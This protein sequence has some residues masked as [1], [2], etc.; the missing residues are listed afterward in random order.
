MANLTT[1]AVIAFK[2]MFAL[3]GL[4][5]PWFMYFFVVVL[6]NRHKIYFVKRTVSPI[7]LEIGIVGILTAVVVPLTVLHQY[8]GYF[9]SLTAK[10][11]EILLQSLFFGFC[12]MFGLA[13]GGHF[14]R[15]SQT[16]LA[17]ENINICNHNQAANTSNSNTI[18]ITTE[19][20]SA[21][22]THTTGSVNE[23]NPYPNWIKYFINRYGIKLTFVLATLIALIL[24]LIESIC[25]A[26][27]ILGDYDHVEKSIV[28]GM[29]SLVLF[30]CTIIVVVFKKYKI[31]EFNDFWFITQELKIYIRAFI[32]TA[33]IMAIVGST[34]LAAKNLH[35]YQPGTDWDVVHAMSCMYVVLLGLYLSYVASIWIIMKNKRRL[36]KI[37]VNYAS[38]NNNSGMKKKQTKHKITKFRQFFD[39]NFDIENEYLHIIAEFG[40]FV[41][42]CISECAVEHLLFWINCVQLS[43]YINENLLTDKG[44]QIIMGQL[45]KD[46]KCD[47][48]IENTMLIKK[49]KNDCTIDQKL[50]DTIVPYTMFYQSLFEQFI[51]RNRA[52]FEINISH[53]LRETLTKDYQIIVQCNIDGNNINNS[54][55][56]DVFIHQIWKDIQETAI[57]VRILIEGSFRRFTTTPN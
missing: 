50:R 26:V 36:E 28:T 20:V 49:L 8:F 24:W 7:L 11:T 13:Y 23:E 53:E 6:R 10:F 51:E 39:A 32:V 46:Y 57:Q 4:L 19:T 47:H 52:P 40:L 12:N 48:F 14:I 33:I 21:N 1:A 15:M 22:T 27:I 2:I 9:D 29:D 35:K 38:N 3:D 42:H 17:R 31:F 41:N 44:E 54:N 5:I 37:D 18:G 34:I 16:Y 43:Q 55:I 25:V 56:K 30:L 45:P